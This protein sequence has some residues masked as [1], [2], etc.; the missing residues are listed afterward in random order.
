MMN[1]IN[2][3]N[4]LFFGHNTRTLGRLYKIKVGDLIYF[5]INGEIAIPIPIKIIVKTTASRV[6]SAIVK[7]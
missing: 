1:F 5:T 6:E 4:P 7:S 3:D 2:N